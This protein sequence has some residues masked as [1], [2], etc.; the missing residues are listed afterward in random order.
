[1]KIV[2]SKNLCRLNHGSFRPRKFG[3]IRYPIEGGGIRQGLQYSYGP[4]CVCGTTPNTYSYDPPSGRECPVH[5]HHIPSRTAGERGQVLW[6]DVPEQ[7]EPHCMCQQGGC[8]RIHR[9]GDSRQMSPQKHCVYTLHTY[10]A[11][12]VSPL[13]LHHTLIPDLLAGRPFSAT[14]ENLTAV[15]FL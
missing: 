10:N 5:H 9:G 13:T 6:C 7:G 2:V 1:M 14:P 12:T 4:H 15:S 3:A 8:S 11:H